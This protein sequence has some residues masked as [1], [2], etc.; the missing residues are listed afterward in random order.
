MEEILESKPFRRTSA[1]MF[2]GRLS[3]AS[4]SWL[5]ISSPHQPKQM[6]EAGKRIERQTKLLARIHQKQ[7]EGF[8][9][10]PF[11]GVEIQT[12]EGVKG[13]DA[14]HWSSDP[15]DQPAKTSNA[16]LITADTFGDQMSAARI[17]GYMTPV[18]RSESPPIR[19]SIED[20]DWVMDWVPPVLNEWPIRF[21]P[22]LS[23][24]RVT[25]ESFEDLC[26]WNED[27]VPHVMITVCDYSDSIAV[28]QEPE[29][30]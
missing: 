26:S 2:W 1:E 4:S 11:M 17:R 19:Q 6:S 21:S 29:S 5:E 9:V 24:E 7:E 10:D 12:D 14:M 23:A 25:P 15:R 3:L 18:S 16:E 28:K 8:E 27:W 30:H 20:M 13:F 22:S